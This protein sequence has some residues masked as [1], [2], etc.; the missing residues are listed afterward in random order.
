MKTFFIQ[1]LTGNRGQSGA[2]AVVVAIVIAL[3]LMFAALSVDVGYLYGVR[4][5]LHNSADAGALAGARF[6]FDEETGALNRDAAIAEASR[7]TQLN[8]SGKE[9]IDDFVVETGH[10]SFASRTFTANAATEQPADWHSKSGAEL[11]ANTNFINAVR[12]YSTRPDTPSF[13]ARI[14]GLDQFFVGAQGVAWI[15]YSIPFEIDL[16]IALCEDKISNE[17]GSPSCNQARM[18]DENGETAMWTNFSQDNPDKGTT[19]STASGNTMQGLT[20]T[21]EP[22]QVELYADKGIGVQNGVQ[23]TV[24]G[25]VSD[26]WIAKTDDDADGKPD[27]PWSVTLP[28]VDCNSSNTCATLVGGAVVDIVWIIYKNDPQMQDVPTQMS[29]EL[30]AWGCTTPAPATYDERFACWKE[31]VDRFDLENATGPPATDTDYEDMYQM[32]NIFFKPK[33][34]IVKSNGASGAHNFGIPAKYP[35]LVL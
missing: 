28:V 22:I 4:N 12:V 10:W 17:D 31:F 19:C 33:C 21:C 2:M 35:K 6:L 27:H 1:Q 3:L 26:C 9:N 18:A 13:F 7:I 16:P 20:D 14:L 15:G 8:K 23:D 34:E 24:Y 30:G 5:E 32:R 25:N 11:D 29:D